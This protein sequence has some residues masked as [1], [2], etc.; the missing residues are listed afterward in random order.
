VVSQSLEAVSLLHEA[1]LAHRGLGNMGSL[2]LTALD[3]Q[4][5][6]TPFEGCEVGLLLV[7]LQALGFSTPLTDSSADRQA[8]A[9]LWLGTD[10]PT[11]LQLASLSLA[12]DLHGL[13]LAL[14]ATMLNALAEVPDGPDGEYPADGL[15][16][17]TGGLLG[18]SPGGSPGGGLLGGLPGL[19][20]RDL[21]RLLDGPYKGDAAPQYDPATGQSLRLGKLEE[22]LASDPRTERACRQVLGGRARAGWDF[23]ASLLYAREEA[24]KGGKDQPPRPT[25]GLLDHPFLD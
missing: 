22:F 6:S 2:G 8:S 1:G 5:K 11:P 16:S 20:V 10:K 19:G 9:L 7:K 25:R 17:A 15:S 4:D 3:S 13:G 18:G 24:A 23:F 12:E 14:L 21:E